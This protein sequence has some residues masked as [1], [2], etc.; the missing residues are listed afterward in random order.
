M[1][2][3]KKKLQMAKIQDLADSLE[4]E[5]LAHFYQR[6]EI[7]AV[8][9]F[10]G[11]SRGIFRRLKKSKA[12]TIVLCG[13]DFMA[14]TISSLRPEL[15]ILIPRHDAACPYSETVSPRTVWE[16]RRDDPKAF[17]VAQAKAPREVK[18]LADSLMPD[19]LTPDFWYDKVHDN[20]LYIL[21]GRIGERAENS[22]S[23]SRGSVCQ[24][25]WQVEVSH[26][27]QAKKEHPEALVAANV[28]C[29]P[30][31]LAMADKIGDS[32][33]LWEF[34]GHHSALEFIVVAEM[35]LAESLGQ[36]FGHKKFYEPEVEIF[37]PNMKLTNLKDLITVLES[38]QLRQ[39]LVTHFGSRPSEGLSSRQSSTS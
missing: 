7:K 15:N 17:I 32:Q 2:S 37:C 21:P 39:G 25:H 20:H 16:I 8:A 24:V 13:V 12:Q 36:T 35:G 3:E 31:V 33:A 27:A 9:D 30:E 10:V 23:G 19:D 4:V 1:Y 29:Q 38:F 26:V 18:E 5:I 28:L 34:C 22:F 14:E 11:G 6:P